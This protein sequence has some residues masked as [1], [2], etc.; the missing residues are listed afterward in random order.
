MRVSFNP[1][2]QEVTSVL[3][4]CGLSYEDIAAES[5]QDFIVVKEGP[6][7]VGVAGLEVFG[8]AA[9]VRSVGVD[10]AHRSRGLGLNLLTAIEARAKERGVDQVYLLTNEAQRFF[11]K[12]GYMAIQRCSAPAGMQ[13]CSQFG[14]SY[15]GSATLLKKW[16]A[17]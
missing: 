17:V 14:L 4:K 9:M 10:A 16:L 13:A 7:P 2:I 1:T 12:H 11:S 6:A 3:M 15:C 8:S 5:L